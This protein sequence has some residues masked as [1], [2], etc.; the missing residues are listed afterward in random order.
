M[1]ESPNSDRSQQATMAEL[2][3]ELSSQTSSLVRQEVELAK[4]ELKTK[5]REAGMGAGLFTVAGVLGLLG[6]GALTACLIALLSEGMDTWVAALIVAA[7]Y[8]A[9]AGVSALMGRDRVREAA[10]LVP[11]QAIETTKEDIEWAKN[12]RTSASR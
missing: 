12:P 9:G 5:G 1:S 10:P 6:A 8:L 7:V 4:A 2:V 3:K 11:E